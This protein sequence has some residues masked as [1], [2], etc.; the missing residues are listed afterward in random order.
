MFIYIIFGVKTICND[1]YLKKI[2]ICTLYK[3]TFED[4]VIMYHIIP[5]KENMHQKGSRY[6]VYRI[7]LPLSFLIAKSYLFSK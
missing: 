6:I 2:K 7:V 4:T 1:L 5:K 3:T